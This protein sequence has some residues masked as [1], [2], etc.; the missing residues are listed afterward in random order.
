VETY[1]M[2]GKRS[3]AQR[4]YSGVANGVRWHK[5]CTTPSGEQC[6]LLTPRYVMPCHTMGKDHGMGHDPPTR[7]WQGPRS[8]KFP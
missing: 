6:S 1:S 8:L 2:R 4:T 3:A 5:H 7:H